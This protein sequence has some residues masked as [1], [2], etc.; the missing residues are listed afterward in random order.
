MSLEVS[1]IEGSDTGA[2]A[3]SDLG[4]QTSDFRPQQRASGRGL[5]SEVRPSVIHI[6]V[7][8]RI[9]RCGVGDFRSDLFFLN[10]PHDVHDAFVNANQV[11]V[12]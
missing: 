8:F 9:S 11:L 6:Y 5:T 1:W 7:Q 4:L 3:A 2:K 12:G 10:L